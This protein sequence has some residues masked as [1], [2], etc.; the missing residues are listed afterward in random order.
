MSLN[1]IQIKSSLLAD[2]YK[3]SL[4]QTSATAVP[5]KSQAKY[6]GTNRKNVIVLV[7]HTSVP[8][9]PNEEL[10]FLTNVLAA[11]KLSVADIG[12]INVHGMEQTNLQ[13]VIDD[14]AKMVLLF[15]V[16]PL[17]IGLP[18]NF[19]AFQLQ[20]FNGRTY[21]QAPA[22]SLI[23]DDKALKTRLWNSLKALFNI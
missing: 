6:L 5:E 3:N 23:A 21:L 19:P 2:L 11:C 8:F 12:I 13:V 17:G 20:G 22:L 18:I 4:V 7:S 15:G 16:E 9:L 1:D 10:S 14:E